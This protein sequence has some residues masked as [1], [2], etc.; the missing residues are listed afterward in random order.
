MH[1]Q[2]QR[3]DSEN[4]REPGNSWLKYTST[5]TR[6]NPWFLGCS[7]CF[8]PSLS[9]RSTCLN[10]HLGVECWLPLALLHWAPT[11][12]P[13]PQH[14]GDL[15]VW[16]SSV[17]TPY[18]IL[19]PL[20]LPFLS[21]GEGHACVC[22]LPADCTSQPPALPC[23]SHQALFSTGETGYWHWARTKTPGLFLKR[24][25]DF[26]SLIP[27]KCNCSPIP[28]HFKAVSLAQDLTCILYRKL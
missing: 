4:C 22:L 11:V 12:L 14:K 8:C 26:P 15:T 10:L 19:F 6:L 24:L 2:G 21:M 18:N 20:E 28:C 23:S 13:K 1:V 27:F 7:S 17:W 9:A 5:S 16:Q 25:R 3:P